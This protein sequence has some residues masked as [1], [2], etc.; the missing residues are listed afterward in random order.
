MDAGLALDLGNVAISLRILV[1]IQWLAVRFLSTR[2]KLTVC[3]T[4]THCL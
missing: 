2:E 3:V 1:R 4:S